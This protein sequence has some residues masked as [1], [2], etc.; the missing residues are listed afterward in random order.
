MHVYYQSFSLRSLGQTHLQA[1][2]NSALE[3]SSGGE[4][5]YGT[6]LLDYVTKRRPTH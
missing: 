4:I 1:S 2:D 6:N 3:D 5:F